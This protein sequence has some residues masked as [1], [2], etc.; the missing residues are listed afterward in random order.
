MTKHPQTRVLVEATERNVPMGGPT[1]GD[2]EQC[3][4]RLDRREREAK[5]FELEI[6][7]RLSFIADSL[8]RLEAQVNTPDARTVATMP[9]DQAQ[10]ID[11]LQRYLPRSYLMEELGYESDNTFR[12][13]AKAGKLKEVVK[14]GVAWVDT[15]SII[16][17]A[18]E[19]TRR[20]HD[21]RS[22]QMER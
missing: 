20:F 13:R 18:D 15:N 19:L 4:R 1:K 8:A 9:E 14:G 5:D 21:W 11:P 22:C 17:D 7:K 16:D 10:R 3:I 12:R 6:L 2:L